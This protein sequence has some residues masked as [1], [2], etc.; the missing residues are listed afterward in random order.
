MGS[1]TGNMLVDDQK[2]LEDIFSKAQL[3]IATHCE[4]ETVI[5]KNMESFKKIYGEDVPLK[6]HP[7]IRSA[8]ACYLSSSRAVAL[9][10]KYNTRL[11]ILHLSTAKE[12]E[13][14]RNDIPLN[15]KRITDTTNNLVSVLSS[16][17]AFNICTTLTFV[18]EIIN[19][20]DT[21][22][23]KMTLIINDIDKQYGTEGQEKH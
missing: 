8:E 16:D 11:H 10:K 17:Q 18:Q 19:R 21:C 13:L 22:I 20:Y 12:M 14:F 7:I 5:R 9:A 15:K 6:Y 4:D 23:N 1:S 3:L 2:A